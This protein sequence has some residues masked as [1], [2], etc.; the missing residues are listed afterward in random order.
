MYES[1]M[2]L[3]GKKICSIDGEKYFGRLSDILVN[4]ETNNIIGI[5]SKNDSLLYR[6]RFFPTEDIVYLDE[7]K[8]YVRGR[9]EKF[10]RVIPCEGEFHSVENDIFKRRAVL[11]DGSDAGK[12][13]NISIDFNLGAVTGFEVGSSLAQDLLNGRKICRIRDKIEICRG[14]VVIKDTLY[15]ERRKKLL[16]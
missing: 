13:Q 14:N 8:V 10:V 16:F 15:R 1:F 4:K 9:G 12:I 11:P 3:K 2:R 6:Y 7:L 5:V